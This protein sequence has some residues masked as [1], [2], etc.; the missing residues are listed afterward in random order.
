MLSTMETV[1][2]AV[3]VG[4]CFGQHANVIIALANKS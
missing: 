4:A 1:R 2:V 3:D